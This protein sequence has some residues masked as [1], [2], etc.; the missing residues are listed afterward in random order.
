[1]KRIAAFFALLALATGANPT[2]VLR[3]L[4]GEMRTASIDIGAPLR[5][6]W[7]RLTDIDALA[8]VRGFE[9]GESPGK[10]ERAGD[11]VQV[12][13]RNTVGTLMVLTLVPADE[14]RLAWE[15]D[16]G[17]AMSHERWVLEPSGSG[18]RVTFEERLAV[19]AP[20]DGRLRPEA[21]R[22]RME[23]DAAFSESLT[24]LKVLCET[25]R[26]S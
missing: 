19:S 11:G 1:M 12:L 7:S 17:G 25:R 5:V 13:F 3:S 8:R 9:C 24:I 21:A 16:D 6:V 22:T 18:T 4:Q 23:R 15:P 26:P 2:P 10:P 20:R 14:L